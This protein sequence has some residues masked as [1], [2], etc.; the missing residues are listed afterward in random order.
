[1]ADFRVHL[2]DMG[3]IRYGDC[4]VVEAGDHRILIDAGHPNDFDGQDGYDSIPTQIESILG[5][6]P[7]RFDLLIV[8]HVHNDHIGCLPKM[9]DADLLRIKTALVADPELGFGRIDNE[10]DFMADPALTPLERGLIAAGTEQDYS[11][12]TADEIVSFLLDA[13]KL[14]DVYKDFLKNLAR[15]GVKVTRYTGQSMAALEQEFADI[16]LRILGPT[17]PHLE[18]CARATARAVKANAK[19]TRRNDA[20]AQDAADAVQRYRQ[21]FA[22]RLRADLLR[23]DLEADFVRDGK[24]NTSIVLKLSMAGK[25][26]LLAGDMQFA[27]AMIKGMEQDMFDIRTAVRDAGP[28]DVVKTSHHTSFNG[29]NDDV[30]ADYPGTKLFLHSGGR[31]D[32][33]HPDTEALNVLKAVKDRIQFARTDRNGAITIHLGDSRP[34]GRTAQPTIELTQGKLNVFTL[35][36]K[37]NP[38]DGQALPPV[39]PVMAP[40]IVRQERAPEGNVEI[41]ARIPHRKTNVTL[42]VDI[43]PELEAIVQDQRIIDHG[44]STKRTG[45]IAE[46]GPA[47]NLAAGRALP[48]L[49][50]VSRIDQLEQNIGRQEAHAVFSGLQRAG[51]DLLELRPGT[52][53][54]A[55]A[56]RQ[57]RA[58]LPGVYKGVVLVGGYDVVPPRRFD[59]IGDTIRKKLEAD[60][61]MGE[62]PDDFIVW[63]DEGYVDLDDD[64]RPELP[65]S[66]IPDGMSASLVQA[67]LQA[68]S[69]GAGNRFGIRNL[70]RPFADKIWTLVPGQEPL[71]TSHPMTSDQIAPAALRSA[72]LY[73]MLHGESNNGRS[74]LGEDNDGERFRAV[75]IDAI[76]DVAG[77]VVFAGCC[78]GALCGERLA[79]DAGPIVPR[80]LGNSLAMQF[81]VAGAKAFIGCTGVHYSPDPDEPAAGGPMHEAFWKALNGGVTAPAQALF[82]AKRE[83]FRR[84]QIP[85]RPVGLQAV[86]SKI[87]AQFTC[88]GLGW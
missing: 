5:A 47:L 81:L 36:P 17:R 9:F 35:N 86:E 12:M 67:S 37:N 29:L 70:L 28:Y 57:V 87:L 66:R 3:D 2:L 8:T 32:P 74:F 13:A 69:A 79:R 49:L 21:M 51:V 76:K 53:D 20:F 42:T 71:Q 62:D 63:S 46:S 72:N 16:G 33:D 14:E 1:M 55:D 27:D 84:L 22:A 75:D 40:P 64:G 52:T 50:F 41:I 48:K 10:P 31:R 18:R 68:T 85:R 82:N 60:P 15:S 19:R 78:W 6:P 77:A 44:Q 88:L 25:S 24:N 54:P 34:G 26:V 23:D 38:D 11:D 56:I 83:Y 7:F 39:P 65:I 80:A 59:T 58:R 43:T 61:E 73:L 30:L 4:I 45:I